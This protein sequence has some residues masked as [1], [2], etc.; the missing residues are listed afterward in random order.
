[1]KYI[2]AVIA[3][4]AM[5]KNARAECDMVA[6]SSSLGDIATLQSCTDMNSELMNAGS[7]IDAMSAV[8]T[9]ACD[10]GCYTDM[11]DVY[12]SLSSECQE[13]LMVPTMEEAVVTA[14]GA[15][16]GVG[17][18]TGGSSST[19]TSSSSGVVG[20]ATS[21]VSSST[22]DSCEDANMMVLMGQAMPSCMMAIQIA[23]QAATVAEDCP[24]IDDMCSCYGE[25]LINIST[26][27]C[28][29]MI[30]AAMDAAGSSSMSSSSSGSMC[31]SPDSPAECTDQF[32]PA[33]M[34]AFD[35]VEEDM[36]SPAPKIAAFAAVV[37]AA[38][39]L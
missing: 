23:Q 29:G 28:G 34:D 6:A 22:G 2:S 8:M 13:T 27:E 3:V 14:C 19:S 38:L 9:S 5:A 26:M 39:V 25:M 11:M 4:L 30:M 12:T 15:Y 35:A 18:A 37:V 7:D 17:S 32:T 31:E 16:G 10:G 24:S 36:G 21:Q 33:Q 1:M 20:S